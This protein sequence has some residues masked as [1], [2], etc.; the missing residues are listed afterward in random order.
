MTWATV[1]EGIRRDLVPGI[2]PNRAARAPERWLD[3]SDPSYDLLFVEFDDQGQPFDGAAIEKAM[4]HIHSVAVTADPF[5]VVF[6]HGWKHG[7]R[8]DD[9]NVVSLR[10][11]LHANA[12]TEALRPAPDRPRRVIGLYVGWRGLSLHWLDLLQNVTFWGRKEAALRVA[13]GSVRELFARLR[14]F[15]QS[16]STNRTVAGSRLV[17]VG[18]SFGGLVVYAA[19][20]EYL[21]ESVAVPDE[22]IDLVVPFGD[23]TILVNPAFEA[24]RYHPLHAILA[25]RRFAPHQVP[26]FLSITA[27]NDW[28]T[29]LVFPLGRLVSF[30]TGRSRDTREHVAN[31]ETMGHVLWMQTHDLSFEEAASPAASTRLTA[32]KPLDD[33]ERRSRLAA[34]D[35]DYQAF[36]HGQ[37]GTDGHLMPGWSRRYTSGALLRQTRPEPDAG[38]PGLTPD[39]PFWTVRASPDIVNGHNGIFRLVFLDFLRQVLDD[40]FR[41]SSSNS[42]R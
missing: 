27:S 6:V 8:D 16:S 13:L 42:A 14:R 41:A 30:Y 17:L 9:D 1:L 5:V 37:T 20:A 32:T 4:G 11:L 10:R 36:R 21:I 23:L 39:N 12:H 40:T 29:G 2:N 34:E 28:A 7:A 35:A 24:S 18:H 26:V 31:Y 38:E 33:D 15:R 25:R 3:Q 22:A 19:V